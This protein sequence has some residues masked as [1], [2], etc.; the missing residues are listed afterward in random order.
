MF[1]ADRRQS[2]S[3]INI[4]IDEFALD[5]PVTAFWSDDRT[6]AEYLLASFE[7]A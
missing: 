1:V 7:N 5:T 4:G 3:A 2:I 6:Y